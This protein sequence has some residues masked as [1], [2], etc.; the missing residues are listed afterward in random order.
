MAT[1]VTDIPTNPV[2]C[3]IAGPTASGKSAIATALAKRWP[4]EIINVDSATIYQHMNIGTATPS[5][6]ERLHTP[7]H[8]LDLIDPT[9]SYSV[10]QFRTDAQNAVQAVLS[11]G[12]IPLLVGGTMMYFNALK[13]GLH[14]LPGADQSVRDQIEIEARAEGWPAMHQKLS[15]V[16]AITAAR[17][18][19]H[20]SQRIQR[21]LEVWRSSGVTLS[22]WLSQPLPQSAHAFSTRLISL[23][24]SDRL[25]LHR[26][27]ENRFDAMLE[28]GLVNEVRA[29]FERGDLNPN[30]PS[31]RCV[32]YRQIWGN[33][34]GE[35]SL[36]DAREQAVAATRQLAKR[37]LTWLR[38]MPERTVIDCLDVNATSQVIDQLALHF[39]PII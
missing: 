27:I 7:H 6:Q 30:M 18:A 37:Q 25:T 29:L 4:I 16:D 3:C 22:E 17:L 1:A 20:D 39:K 13:N 26:R 11:R 33:L 21:A 34:T 2:V 32:G 8:L 15:Q 10:A 35:L 36:A 19:P 14:N 5:A 31:I 12:H 23:E 28:E 9:G 38:G 24:P